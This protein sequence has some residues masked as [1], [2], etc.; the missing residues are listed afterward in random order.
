[1]QML[2]WI[3]SLLLPFIFLALASRK[4]RKKS[5][6][7]PCPVPELPIIGHLHLLK[8]PLHRKYDHLSKKLGPIFSLQLGTRLAVVISS[9]DAVE[10]CF[11]KNDTIFA[12]RP[13][14][15]AGKYFGYNYT[16]LVASP[17]G[18]HWRNLR[19]FTAVEVFSPS[20]LNAFCFTREDEIRL[21]I[22]KLYRN[23]MHTWGKVELQS[24]LSELTYN[25]IMRM[26][27]GKRYFGEGVD[28]EEAKHFRELKKQAFTR[29]G[30]SNP[31]DFFPVLRWI[32]Y[33][34]YEK[35]LSKLFA[36][37]DAFFQ[38]LIDECR[39]VKNTDSI[40][41]HLLRLQESQPEYYS[42]DI[43]KGIIMVMLT[44]GTDTSAVTIEWAMSCLL[45]NPEKLTKARVEIDGLTG[46]NRLIE[47]SDLP[48]LQYLQHIVSETLRLFPAAPLLVPHE[49]S[50]ACKIGG[51]DIPGGTILLV[52]AWAIHR[53]PNIWDDPDSFIPE[54]FEGGGSGEIGAA[55]VMAFGM[56][57]RACPGTALANRIVGLTVGSLIQGF[58]WEGTV[59]DMSEGE[60]VTMPKAVPLVATC[61]ARDVLQRVLPA[62][63]DCS[64]LLETRDY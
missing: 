38:T 40:I 33:K 27:A 20:R 19:R 41:D 23:S 44:A 52:N 64:S 30:T 49:S 24:L 8:Q 48:N 3:Y 22:H 4:N 32:D 45:N 56:G 2:T 62:S 34:G 5:N 37:I 53:D 43:I 7:P 50:S 21:L 47:E 63:A 59:V 60:G 61:R 25:I 31:A 15:I 13:R 6:L 36:E 57:R 9:P 42:D 16:S 46:G 54:R 28:N 18:S 58:D 55:K 1:M 39:L 17:Y 26:I 12:N 11:S 14:L 29:G 51:F 35:K 10:E